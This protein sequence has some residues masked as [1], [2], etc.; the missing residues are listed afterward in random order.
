M[1]AV[2][3]R[4][5]KRSTSRATRGSPHA[6]VAAAARRHHPRPRPLTPTQL[7][8]IGYDLDA[9]V[10]ATPNYVIGVLDPAA[11]N[12]FG[13]SPPK[14]PNRVYKA[15]MVSRDQSIAYFNSIGFNHEL[16]SPVG[17]DASNFNQA[18]IPASGLLTRQDCCKT[19]QQVDLFGGFPGNFEGNVPSFDGGCVDNPFRWCDNLSN[20]DPALLTLMSK[21]FANTVVRMAFD[22]KVMSASDNLVSKPKLPISSETSRR[23]A[24]R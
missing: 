18:G 23:F 5:P 9:D 7:S 10:M 8:H 2:F 14:F 6:S 15:S 11:P 3:R 1:R 16:F 12:L 20:N 24:V 19:Q 21:A 13:G 4:F 22:T 17:T